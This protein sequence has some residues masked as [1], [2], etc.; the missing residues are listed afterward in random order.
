LENHII[1]DPF[2][3]VNEH[4]M[5]WVYDSDWYYELEFDIVQKY[6]DYK[7]ILLCF[8]GLDT[9]A[10]IYLNG[11]I[12]GS[13]ENMF[14]RYT[15][16]VKS[17]IQKTGNKILINFKSPTKKA[18]EDIEKFNIRLNTGYAAIPG[19]PYLRKAQYSFGWDWGPKLPDIGVWKSV[20]LVGYDEIKI[21]SV[22]PYT[23]FKYNKDPLKLKDTYEIP[24]LEPTSV[25]LFIEID[26]ASDIDDFSK[27]GYKVIVKICSP[28]NE[29]VSKEVPL[30][31]K[32][33]KID[34]S[35]QNAAAVRKINLDSIER[36][37]LLAKEYFTT[38]PEEKEFECI[39]TAC[40]KCNEVFVS[41]INITID[42]LGDLHLTNYTYN[43]IFRYPVKEN[44]SQEQRDNYYLFFFLYYLYAFLLNYT[45]LLEMKIFG[46]YR[47]V[48]LFIFFPLLLLVFA[49]GRPENRFS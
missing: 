46:N 24:T 8:N 40:S 7:N 33:E 42:K 18:Q 26:L 47:R 16:D 9:I 4:E 20:Q 32:K 23:K 41:P 29:V 43:W 3:G 48:G 49:L 10:D 13:T 5:K 39:G 2:Y 12:L 21:A 17:K 34:F 31:K 19:V 30:R 27:L 6:L 14:L 15:F 35:L 44:D 22:Y 1:E 45:I 37:K 11:E 36:G 28:D 38:F 25:I